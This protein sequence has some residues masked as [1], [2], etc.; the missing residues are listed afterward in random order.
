[1]NTSQ[2]SSRA[3]PSARS[4]R[5]LPIQLTSFVG[6]EREIA[7][8]KRLLHTTRLLTIS[9]PG[10]SGKTRLA[11]R[12]AEELRGNGGDFTAINWVDLT[13]LNEA[14]LVPQAV[15]TVLGVRPAAG[16][17]VMDALIDAL[18][19]APQLLVLDNCEHLVA[20]SSQLAYDLLS[21]C[22]GLRLLATSR[23]P[24][25]V[26]GETVWAIP[27]LSLPQSDAAPSDAHALLAQS[28]AVRLFAERA[29]AALPSFT[30]TDYNAATVVHLCR[31]LDGIPLALELAA[32]RVRVLAVEDMLSHLDN[33]LSLLTGGQRGL[34]P[35]HQTLRATIDW[36][37][38][39]LDD[40]ERRL[41][42]RLSVFAGGFTLPAA[43]AIAADSDRD[44]VLNRL[45]LLVDKSLVVAEA[46][47]EGTTWYRMLETVRQYAESQLTPEEQTL[48]RQRHYAWYLALAQESRLAMRGPAREAW[49]A[50]LDHEHDNF[51]GALEWARANESDGGLRLAAAL[52]YFWAMRG[53]A[54][55]GRRWVDGALA[56]H[57][58]HEAAAASTDTALLTARGEAL[59]AAAVLAAAQGDLAASAVSLEQ[60]VAIGWQ[61]G[62]Q[63]GIGDGLLVLGVG[64]FWQ[65]QLAAARSLLTQSLGLFGTVGDR[66]STAV[67]L[68]WLGEIERTEGD[69][70][71]AQADY[72]E[73]LKGF[74]DV[75]DDWGAAW[76]VVGQAHL[77]LQQGDYATASA[78][79][80]ESLPNFRKLDDKWSTGAALNGLAE[81]ARRQGDYEQARALYLESL[82]LNK[83]IAFKYSV[84][85][86]L[87]GLA[88][89]SIERGQPERGV[90]L[91][92]AAA[93]V[94]AQMGAQMDA[95][96]LADQAVMLDTTRAALG[97][98]AFEAAWAR[99]QRMSLEEAIADAQHDDEPV[100][101]LPPPT[102]R[103]RAAVAL[104]T[105]ADGGASLSAPHEW[106]RKGVQSGAT[107]GAVG[108]EALRIQA[109][110]RLQV[111]QG[112]DVIP[113]EAWTYAKPRELLLY[114]LCHG[115]QT[116]EQI[117]VAL[118]PDASA[119]QLRANF[120][121]AVY[122]LRRA[123][124]RAEWIVFENEEYRFNRALPCWYDVDEFEAAL[125]EVRQRG[126]AGNDGDTIARL[127]YAV[128]L[129]QDDFA[130]DFQDSQ[131]CEVKREELRRLHLAA[132]VTLG[133]R[134][135]AQ[136]RYEAA[137]TRFRQAVE[138][139]EYLEAA[140]R[141]IMRCYAG[142]GEPGQAIRH[143]HTL[144]RLLDNDLGAPPAAETQA[145]YTQL[146]EGV[147]LA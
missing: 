121:T 135:V 72:H 36:S 104:H 87:A 123:L 92:G 75:G 102:N 89:V 8:I 73:S 18:Q 130:L 125:R 9:G 11:L 106:G 35:R 119:A 30:L 58:A 23:E 7:E 6:R 50:R 49:M 76:A 65:G 84:A 117:G 28:E 71:A 110:G 143:Y 114:L 67:A 45:S 12:V 33:L 100:T 131:W 31:R 99:G 62:N 27:P 3:L 103:P 64:A 46:G 124:G 14:D 129:Y 29:Q 120:R 85:L 127:E 113:A 94:L 144:S 101:A 145:L 5:P 20:A 95:A 70:A 142:L 55:E 86:A 111:A 39:L 40:D 38:S 63:Q 21:A 2:P 122:H 34:P 88:G 48:A 109:L 140:H 66:W 32:A 97:D 107:R 93:A 147:T 26:L 77:A 69:A 91:F 141:G 43:R 108:D 137:L 126:G 60:S 24:L 80:T 146:R 105:D 61:V 17:P 41:F 37:Y 68:A 1:M 82:A 42:R 132:L 25:G 138:R 44:D 96:R 139:D 118:W 134:L 115:G 57:A 16:Q 19:D 78:L 56:A 10:G 81:V 47:S 54:S 90:R 15:A 116:K 79:Y 112:A 52:G 83:A 133:R 128:G 13:A 4:A 22:P 98:V 59:Y 136:G 74:R 51:R 53:Y